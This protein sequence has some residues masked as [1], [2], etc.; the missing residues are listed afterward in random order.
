MR[1][2]KVP[3]YGE[4]AGFGL[5]PIDAPA[6]AALERLLH[7]R[8]TAPDQ[9]RKQA[10]EEALREVLQNEHGVN[11]FTTT[12]GRRVEFRYRVQV[13]KGVTEE[14]RSAFLA[15][16]GEKAHGRAEVWAERLVAEGRALPEGFDGH[17]AVRWYMMVK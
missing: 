6:I 14:Q 13:R 8:D 2:R 3:D 1:K 5:K 12:D 11:G 10:A 17:F 7:E 4:F 9:S 16:V 15:S